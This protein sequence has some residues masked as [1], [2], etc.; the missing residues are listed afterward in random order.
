MTIATERDAPPLTTA[1]VPRALL[2]QAIDVDFAYG[3]LQVLFG[4]SIEVHRG[5]ALALLGANGAGKTTLLRVIAG[6]NEASGGRVVFDD[7][8]ITGV[9]A[10]AL[11]AQGLVFIPGERAIFTDMTV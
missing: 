3:N 11:S 7:H 5:E 10:E 8:D 6:L 1:G 4:A 2:L 9:P